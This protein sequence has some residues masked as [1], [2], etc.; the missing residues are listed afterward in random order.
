LPTSARDAGDEA[1]STRAT[2][3]RTPTAAATGN[4]GNHGKQRDH[5]K[6][7]DGNQSDQANHSDHGN[8]VSGDLSP[9]ALP[10][11]ATVS[12]DVRA[13]QDRSQPE[14][15]DPSHFGAV[16][17]I[18][19]DSPST[20]PDDI[21]LPHWTEPPTGQ[22][23]KVLVD[24][25]RRDDDS[26]STYGAS[27]RWRDPSSEWAAA[28]YSDV[29]DLADDLPREGALND[30]DRPSADDFF[31]FEDLETTARSRR[32]G[33]APVTPPA[34][35]G[36]RAGGRARPGSERRPG[37][38]PVGEGSGSGP[39]NVP[40]AVGAGLGLA[41]LAVIL[42]R[43]GPAAMMA[44]VT[45]AVGIGAAELL[46][47]A[48]KVGY[49][50]ATLVG[51]AAAAG[52]PLAV[53][54]R[55][56]EAYPLVMFL[57]VAFTMFW[58]LFGIDTERPAHNV[59]ITLLAVSYVG[60]FGSFAALI[61][62]AGKPIGT[63]MLLAVIIPT[64]AA[65]VGAYFVGRNAGRSPLSPISPGKTVEGALGGF[66]AAI[67]ASVILNHFL[68]DLKP[69]SGL[70]DAAMLG[71]VIGI[72]SLLGD[73]SESLLKR[74]FGVKDMGSVIPEH[75]GVLDRFDALLFALPASYYL[76]RLLDLLPG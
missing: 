44:M 25:E 75:G 14:Q 18:K 46:A 3:E 55:G 69:F 2:P 23:P 39:R 66:A 36:E 60:L 67:T 68:L 11:D 50:P 4:E 9:G 17:I 72:V 74:G 33:P 73:L 45:V 54:W 64:V 40:V 12:H 42:L 32:T 19:V 47:T 63:N 61:L 8:N 34:G 59:G 13:E 58:Y 70:W 7:P 30:A 53:Y 56:P 27:P 22:V 16:P 57:A 48:R 1:R 76:A 71:V 52:L 65:D 38:G 15:A 29:S 43:I 41:V 6:R 49:H 51:L 26:W 5:G 37:T 10:A 31:S 21:E 62:R 35:G 24:E 20:D 28:D